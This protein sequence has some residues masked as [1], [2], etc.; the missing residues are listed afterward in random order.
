MGVGVGSGGQAVAMQVREVMY[1]QHGW[2]GTVHPYKHN[3]EPIRSNA[4]VPRSERRSTTRW[5]RSATTCS[6]SQTCRH[7][8]RSADVKALLLRVCCSALARLCSHPFKAMHCTGRS[9]DQTSIK[10]QGTY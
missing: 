4:T 10:G 9:R 1:G 2:P 7:D 8:G 6:L 3:R 5:R